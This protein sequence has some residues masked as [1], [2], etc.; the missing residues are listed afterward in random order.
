MITFTSKA[1]FDKPATIL[2]ID[3]TQLQQKKI[4]AGSESLKNNIRALAQ[5]GQI[6]GKEGE[7][8]PLFLN[9]RTV[10][11]TGVGKSSDGFLTALRIAVRKAILSSFLSRFKEIEIVPHNDNDETIQATIEGILIGG[12]SWK[13]YLTKD[14]ND[15]SIDMEGKKFFIAAPK[16]KLFEE[17]IAICEGVQLTRDLI[18]DNADT[19]T[20][21]FLE[22]AIRRIVQGKKQIRLQILNA[23][24]LKAKGL[25][26]HLAVNQGSP[27]EPK[28]IIVRYTGGTAKDSYS[29]I[30]GKGITFD[31][32]GLNL[33]PTGSIET[34]RGDMS[35]AAA[36]I[37][38]LKNTIALN[39]KK[40]VIFAVAIAENAIG[41]RSF[42]PGDV[43]R[44][45]SGKT[46][47]IGN[48]DAEGRLVLADA[49]SYIVRNYKPSH[50]IDIATLTGACVVALGHDYSGLISTNEELA[51]AIL[52]CG[53]KTDD[54]VWRLPSYP[55][56]KNYVKSQYADIKNI[57]TIKGAGGAC[58]A[59]EFLRQF[60]EGTKWAHLDIAG[61]AF[62]EGQGRM[63][64]GY[65]ATG[66][67]VR[68]LTE[69]LKKVELI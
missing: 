27:K 30:V 59:A 1:K 17:T 61:T 21:E 37:G 63:Y 44:G 23:K 10:L 66:A 40:N 35:G 51:E 49:I 38:T 60:S 14:K 33:K 18:N 7:L 16:K 32:G 67:G 3:Q 57:G 11:I 25:N 43:I 52:N 15:K 24:E 20:S 5:T 53:Q 54:R 62:S 4:S 64:F 29:A 46:V 34:M 31:T 68:L 45:Y 56:I 28:L 47:E 9:N 50:L 12:Y 42:K 41:S 8:F 13:K 36:V 19:V 58:T 39:L 65:G 22:G 6:T 55:E 2:L 48:T 69:Y 26:L